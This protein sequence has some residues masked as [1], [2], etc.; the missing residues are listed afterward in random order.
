MLRLRALLAFPLFLAPVMGNA[1]TPAPS[2]A[3]AWR[4]AD[5]EAKALIGID[6]ARIR[7]SQAGTMIREKWLATGGAAGLPGM[8][9]LD[10][11]D[12]V[13]ISSPGINPLGDSAEAPILI[14]IQGHFDAAKVHQV[15]ARLGAK[16]QSYNSFQVYRPQGHTAQG[17][18]KNTAWVLFDAGTILY[19]DA[20]SV[21]AALDRNQFAASSPASGPLFARAAELNAGYDFWVIMDA[22]ELVSND[23]VAALFRG[24]EWAAEAQ[25]FEAGVNLRTGLAADIT[26]RFSSEAA[27]KHITAELTRLIGLVAKDKSRGSQMQEIAKKLKFNLDGSAAKIALRLSEQELE[28]S[29]AAYAASRK[30]AAQAA[31]AVAD[32]APGLPPVPT[33]SPAAPAKAAPNKPAVIRIEGLD[34]GPREIPFPDPQH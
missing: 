1:Q 20:R 10:D 12:R 3:T 18:A 24:G 16:P 7:Q 29:T 17:E 23:Q 32:P 4:F 2:D 14:A 19:G 13:L 9:L 11:V 26:V 6:W 5:P 28:K 21:F 34:E 30:E 31:V 27:A 22:A 33:S 25:G 8:E 15:F